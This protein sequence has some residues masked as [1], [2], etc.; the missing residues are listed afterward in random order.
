M[1]VRLDRG[2][3]LERDVP[4]PVERLDALVGGD[5][6]A[7]DQRR[8]DRLRFACAWRI[9]PA[10]RTASSKV[11]S[12]AAPASP[13]ASASRK[14]A[15]SSLGESSSSF[16][17]S[18][19]RRAVEGQWMQPQR[20][21]LLVLAHAVQLEP[22]RAAHEELPA[23]GRPAAGVGEERV[24]LDE[25]R[26]DEQ[27][28]GPGERNRRRARARTD[29]RSRPRTTR[30]RSARAA[31]PEPC[32]R[33]ASPPAA[34]RSTAS[35]SPSRAIRSCATSA[36]RRQPALDV[37]LETDVTRRPPRGA[38]RATPSAAAASAGGAAAPRARR[39]T[40]ASTSPTASG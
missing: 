8:R 17:I 11:E 3:Q 12:G 35:C 29:P 25:P 33:R 34:R 7:D 38:R 26:I 23:A 28:A 31:R 19:P 20:L 9:D 5:A 1:A 24:E 21:A 36:D 37:E 16:T 15:A 40:T 6:R 4:V 10:A 32:S 39:R 14:T 27:R 13:A 22:G 18:S 30:S 2:E